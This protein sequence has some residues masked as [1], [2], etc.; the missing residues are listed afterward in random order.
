MA[1]ARKKRPKKRSGKAGG[2][3]KRK[4]GPSGKRKPGPSGKRK[5]KGPAKRG[6]KRKRGGPVNYRESKKLFKGAGFE[7]QLQWELDRGKSDDAGSGYRYGYTLMWRTVPGEMRKHNLGEPG[8]FDPNNGHQG[9]VFGWKRECSMTDNKAKR[10]LLACHRAGKLSFDQMKAVRRCLAY[11]WQLVGTRKDLV[12]KDQLNW[13]SIKRTW[14]VVKEDQCP[15]DPSKKTLPTV[16]PTPDEL[17]RAWMSSWHPGMK[18]SLAKSVVCR[19]AFFDLFVLGSR[20][21][22][23]IKRLKESRT[24]QTNSS[25]GWQCT[26]FK[27]GRAKL[28]GAKKGTRPWWAWMPCW[29]PDGKHQH[30]SPLARYSLGTDGNPLKAGEVPFNEQCPLAGWEFTTLWYGKDEARRYPKWNAGKRSGLYGNE[31]C[32]DIKNL[33]IDWMLDQGVGD[34]E[35]RFDTNSGRKALAGWCTELGIPYEESMEYHADLYVT[36]AGSYQEGCVK[37]NGAFNRRKQSKDPKVVLKALMKLGFWFG[38]GVQPPAPPL[39]RQE[40][41]MDLM[42]RNMGLGDAADRIRSNLP[43]K[44]EPEEVKGEVLGPAVKREGKPQPSS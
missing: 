30:V 41:Y 44:Q 23:D 16:I 27:G 36:W 12:R 4:A 5:Q 7:S 29:C 28:F 17:K 31:N 25:A 15:S 1:G 21:N 6:K 42:A 24:H 34:P 39:N 20:S 3:G 22:E 26:R 38:L 18:M 32:G 11:S 2:S 8:S 14:K 35:M 37:M 43:D 13:P 9:E 10:I 19:R 33:A 40:R